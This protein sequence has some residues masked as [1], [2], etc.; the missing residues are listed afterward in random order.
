MSLASTPIRQGVLPPAVALGLRAN[1]R[2]FWLLVLVNAFVGA[3]VGMERTVLPL[4]A[5]VEFGLASKSAVLSFIATFG[6]VKAVTNLF[7]GRLSDSYGRK[8]VLLAG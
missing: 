6:V 1:W 2:Q 4:L 3:M 8:H 7:A 5:Q